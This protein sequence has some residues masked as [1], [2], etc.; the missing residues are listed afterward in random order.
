MW[1]CVAAYKDLAACACLS[2]CGRTTGHNKL[3]NV[4][5]HVSLWFLYVKY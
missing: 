1:G 5:L 3:I 2:H 4:Y